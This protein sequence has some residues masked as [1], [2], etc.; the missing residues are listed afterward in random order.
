MPKDLTDDAT[1]RVDR[2][3]APGADLRPGDVLR[4]RFVIERLI[5]E[6]GMGKVFLA[7][8]REAEQ[9][10]P[11]VA[12]KMLGDQFKTHP[13]ALKALRREATQSRRLNHPNIVN[14]YD[15]D[16]TDQGVF[17][18]MEYMEGQSLDESLRRNPGG[19]RL[20][21]AW[22]IIE[23]CGQG[24]H[25]LH[26]Q[27]VIHSDFKPSNVFLTESGDVKVL[28]LGIART[29][30]ETH[31]VQGTTRFDPDALG[32][33]TPQYASCEMFQGLTPT[34]QDDLFAL[35]CVAYEL[36]AGEHP[37][38]RKTAAEAR[39]SKL[40]PKP[41]RGLKRR[42]WRALKSALAFSRSDRP[43][44][45]AHFLAEMAPKKAAGSP[46]PWI[47]ATAVVAAAAGAVT[48]LQ[49]RSADDRFMELLL[50]Q[51]AENPAQPEP[52]DKAESWLQQGN[53]FLEFG[54][55]SMSLGESERGASQLL[56]GPSSAFQSY[57]LVLTRTDA[58]EAKLKA[59]EGMLR[60]SQVFRDSASAMDA[61][62]A[63]PA[64]TAAVACQG[65]MVNRFDPDLMD[66]LKKLHGQLPRGAGS[67]AE[68]RELINSG[69]ISL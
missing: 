31:A 58:A 27:H 54:A 67:V 1:I 59:A 23:A 18:V 28:D 19:R 33:L 61:S 50:E 25:Y 63:D 43:A 62:Q 6:G 5:G 47:A 38:E 41:P 44:T 21:E 9:S 48:M 49:M 2:R 40:V 30:D 34:A 10:N 53:F 57:R 13:Q 35:G 68:C 66:L 42:H 7:V 45:V 14:V 3:N 4:G 8:D 24:L 37:Y 60:I 51:Y 32:A 20:A 39:A 29:L 12:L 17:M 69:R 55:R 46:I 36:L 64:E 15:F 11:Y 56:T 22:P 26:K 16:R 52:A 65:L